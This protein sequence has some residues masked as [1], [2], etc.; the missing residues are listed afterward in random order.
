[1]GAKRTSA[2]FR[3]RMGVP[4]GDEPDHDVLDVGQA[5]DERFAANQ[6]LLFDAFQISAARVGVVS[7][8][9]FQHPA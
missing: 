7:F 8:Q 5:R 6:R 9:R 3:I 2:T 1:M 4:F